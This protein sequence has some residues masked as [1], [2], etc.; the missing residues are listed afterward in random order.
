MDLVS[1][2]IPY[3]K[4]KNFIKKTLNSILNQSYKNYEIIIVYDDPIKTDY[5]YLKKITKKNKKIKI[6][7]NNKNLGVGYSRNKGI[8]LAK[9][10]YIAFIDADDIWK[11]NKLKYQIKY[12]KKNNHDFTYTSYEVINDTNNIIS[13]RN[14]PKE[15]SFKELLVDCKIGL[16][17]VVLKKKILNKKIK[18]P[19]IKTK[20]DLVLW[21]K[22]SKNHK[23]IGISKALTQWRKTE[24][25]LSSNTIQKLFDGFK[26]Y[27][28]HLRINPLK[29]FVYLILLSINYLKKV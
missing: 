10:Q 20:E 7:I 17:T 2:I 3:Y 6:I 19:S 1:I 8:K 23:L 21:L 25:S 5:M 12:M 11:R 14:A 28:K 22:I 13:R 24:S 27:N 16:S 15:T 26:V 9:G 29:S 4:K 18:F